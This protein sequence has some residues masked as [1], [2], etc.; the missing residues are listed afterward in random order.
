MAPVGSPRECSATPAATSARTGAGPG[1][2][3]RYD[4]A[5]GPASGGGVGGAGPHNPTTMTDTQPRSHSCR[6][7]TEAATDPISGG[8]GFVGCT[9]MAATSG[10]RH[11]VATRHVGR[12]VGL[13][14][15][16]H[17]GE[18]DARLIVFTTTGFTS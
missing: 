13:A 16:S 11:A 6:G 15:G 10:S 9:A 3:G 7:G 14:P 18:G 1:Q 12:K 8:N 5:M 4:V 17:G 2:R